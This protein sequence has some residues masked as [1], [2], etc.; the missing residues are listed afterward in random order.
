MQ[1]VEIVDKILRQIAI[2]D[3]TRTAVDDQPISLFETTI[4]YL[5][6]L[7]SGNYSNRGISMAFADKRMQATIYSLAPSAIW[8][9]TQN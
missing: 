5:G 6:G 3:F 9:K 8:F 7:L 2:T 4:R 1:Q